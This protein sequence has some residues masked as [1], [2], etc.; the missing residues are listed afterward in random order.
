MPWWGGWGSGHADDWIRGA[1]NMAF[2]GEYGFLTNVHFEGHVYVPVLA[3]FLRV[4]GLYPGLLWFGHL[5][6][7]LSALLPVLAAGTVQMTTG[8]LVA[9]LASGL[10]VTFDPVLLWF[11]FNGWSDS[12]TLFATG[13]AFFTFVAAARRVTAFRMT[14][15]GLSLGLLALSH[16]TW[17]WPAILWAAMAWPLLRMRGCWFPRALE[18]GESGPRGWAWCGMPLGATM[19]ALMAVFAFISIRFP[20]ALR[21]GASEGGLPLFG[22]TTTRRAELAVRYVPLDSS[23][24]DQILLSAQL[25]A[26][27][28]FGL[29]LGEHVELFIDAHFATAIPY[30]GLLVMGLNAILLLVGWRRLREGRIARWGLVLGLLLAVMAW[31]VGGPESTAAVTILTVMLMVLFIPVAGAFLLVLA[32]ILGSYLPAVSFWYVHFRQTNAFVY[33]FLLMAGISLGTVLAGSRALVIEVGDGMRRRITGMRMLSGIVYAA[34]AITLAVG[35]E[36]WLDARAGR[37]EEERYLTWLGLQM[38]DRAVLMTSGFVDPWRVRELTGAVVYYDI[39][40]GARVLVDGEQKIFRRVADLYPD[41][42]NDQGTSLD[43][44]RQLNREGIERWYYDPRMAEGQT[45]VLLD[46]LPEA[47][48]REMARLSVRA[49]APGQAGHKAYVVDVD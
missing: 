31:W 5:L 49:T 40:H 24:P 3:A 21:S 48:T 47:D 36:Q 18:E 22:G 11:G 30:Y 17:V 32:P 38:D 10:L 26:M 15:F 27:W 42:A 20:E 35:T 33:G 8:R 39:E 4:F 25:H 12:M 23:D 6:I 44:V 13:L 28:N 16:G 37:V 14:A 9:A 34:L 1:A 45:E 29:D 19:A 41:T 43:V 2:R 7:I 46:L